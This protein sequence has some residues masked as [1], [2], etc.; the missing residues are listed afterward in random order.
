VSTAAVGM[1]ESHT[2]SS[3]PMQTK[4]TSEEFEPMPCFACGKGTVSSREVQGRA[5]RYRDLAQVL[6]AESLVVPACDHCTEMLL[7]GAQTRR[8]AEIL[9]PA[10]TAERQSQMQQ[11][12]KEFMAARNTTQGIA[13]RLLGLS[14]GYLSKLL[15]GERDPDVQV[16]RSVR[17]LPSLT[18]AVV[19]RLAVDEDLAY[20][21]PKLLGE[22][23]TQ[24]TKAPPAKRVA[25]GR[26][27]YAK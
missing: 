1:D 14:Q 13:E 11:A 27:T 9:Q 22:S 18:D 24:E 5:V 12:I 21:L 15:H 23:T 10:Y 7:D 8:L 16:F 19:T 20:L 2:I 4:S 26:A 25:E 17:G 3:A 6:I